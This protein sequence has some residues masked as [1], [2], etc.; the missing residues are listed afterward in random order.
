MYYIGTAYQ[1]P[2]SR[3]MATMKKLTLDLNEL[4]IESFESSPVLRDQRATVQAHSDDDS[5]GIICA[6]GS[7]VASC[8]YTCTYS[9]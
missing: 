5:K 8:F 3:K 9:T 6:M 2:N 4:R 1:H 7:W